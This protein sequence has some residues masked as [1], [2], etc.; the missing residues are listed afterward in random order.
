MLV[1]KCRKIIVLYN[2][3][4]DPFGSKFDRS[5]LSSDLKE[6]WDE[7]LKEEL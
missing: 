1:F 4:I 7:I 6:K 2:S 3:A 5:G